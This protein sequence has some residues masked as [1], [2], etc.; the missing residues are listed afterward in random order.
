[1]VERTGK[2][3]REVDLLVDTN[4]DGLP[5]FLVIAADS[6]LVL[7]GSANGQVLGFV[8]ELTG[9]TLVDIWNVSAPVNGSTMVIY[10]AASDFGLSDGSGAFD[11]A[12]D[13]SSLEGFGEDA[14]SGNASFDPYHSALSQGDFIALTHG[15]HATL[16]VSIDL[17]QFADAPAL[18]WMVVTM[19][20]RNGGA[21]A[22]LVGLAGASDKASHTVP[23]VHL[24]GNG[25]VIAR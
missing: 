4:R 12:V 17:A 18:G 23:S 9:G 21:Q 7:T 10:A 3:L 8:V 15:G 16:P 6:G 1:M 20:D 2:D 14:T 13:A 11:Y 5:D 25:H 22:D 24:R 19:D